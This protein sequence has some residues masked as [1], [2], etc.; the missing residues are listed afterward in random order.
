VARDLASADL[1]STV[2]EERLGHVQSLLG[3]VESTGDEAADRHL[4]RATE[5]TAAALEA[6]DTE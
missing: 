3:E 6:L 4:D 5:T 1:A 2:V